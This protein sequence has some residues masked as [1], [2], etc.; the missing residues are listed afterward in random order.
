MTLVE[1]TAWVCGVLSAATVLAVFAAWL[2]W[3]PTAKGGD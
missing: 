1:Q 2:V 3:Y